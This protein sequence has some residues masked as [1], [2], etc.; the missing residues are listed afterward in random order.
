MEINGQNNPKIKYGYY[1]NLRTVAY[2]RDSIV[3]ACRYYRRK[4]G[5]IS[6]YQ[7][8]IRKDYRSRQLLIHML[9]TLGN[10]CVHSKSPAE[11]G[12]NSYY[13]KT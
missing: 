8:A 1:G 9:K 4:N 2:E 10:I 12:F 3:A 7:F 13:K 5:D 6:L 11:T